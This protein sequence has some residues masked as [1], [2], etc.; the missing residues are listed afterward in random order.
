LNLSIPNS[1][2]VKSDFK[3]E[4]RLDNYGLG[5]IRTRSSCKSF[6]DMADFFAGVNHPPPSLSSLYFEL[7]IP[8]SFAIL[9]KKKADSD[10]YMARA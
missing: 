5:V 3:K 9:Q 10:Y 1:F 2:W 6:V 8:S 7:D 4:V